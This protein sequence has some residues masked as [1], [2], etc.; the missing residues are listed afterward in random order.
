MSNCY[1]PKEKIS[2]FNSVS[3]VHSFCWVFQT[4]ALSSAQFDSSTTTTA[5][6]NNITSSTAISNNSI[7]QNYHNAD[8]GILA[9][10]L[11]YQP[12]ISLSKTKLSPPH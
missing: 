2:V 6:F 3:L 4:N 11:F 1:V 9:T 12:F 5:I 10:N 7:F 8:L